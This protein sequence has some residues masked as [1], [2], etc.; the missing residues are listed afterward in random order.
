LVHHQGQAEANLRPQT[1]R[2]CIPSAQTAWNP[3]YEGITTL[4]NVGKS[5]PSDTA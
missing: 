3:E 5:L 1:W 2:H 4:W